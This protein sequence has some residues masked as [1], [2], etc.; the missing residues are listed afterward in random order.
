MF[1]MSVLS[2]CYNYYSPSL[3]LYV[4]YRIAGTFEGENFREF[5][6]FVAIR[7]CFSR[8]LSHVRLNLTHTLPLYCAN[9]ES[10]FREITDSQKF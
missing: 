3:A 9:R 5:R 6:V 8:D 4:T 2:K 7:K 10:Y 1:M